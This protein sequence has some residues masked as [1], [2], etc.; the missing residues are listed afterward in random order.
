M[1]PLSWP[2]STGTIS[3]SKAI[4]VKT[5]MPMMS[6]DAQQAAETEALHPGG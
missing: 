2:P 1:K 4:N 5:K 3:S 6:S